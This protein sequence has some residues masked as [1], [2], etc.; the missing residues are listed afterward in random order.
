METHWTQSSYLFGDYQDL[1]RVS[2][3]FVEPMP[4]SYV[5]ISR[6][7]QLASMIFC[8]S[9]EGSNAKTCEFGQPS[10]S[11]AMKIPQLAPTSKTTGSW[12]WIR[13]T[14]SFI[15]DIEFLKW[16]LADLSAFRKY[17]LPLNSN[18][19]HMSCSVSS[20]NTEKSISRFP[21]CPGIF[22]AI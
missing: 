12:T 13:S 21:E 22:C 15:F 20:L 19:M 2:S 9:I 5:F 7:A 8:N 3:Q 1:R 17:E 10:F 16:Y 18:S 11:I 14:M 4:K 6:I